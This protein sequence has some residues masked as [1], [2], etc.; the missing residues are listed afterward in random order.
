MVL[1]VGVGVVVTGG[2]E[3]LGDFVVLVV[4]VEGLVVV[5]VVVDLAVLTC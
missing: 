3:M 5:V 4:D 2:G 1:I